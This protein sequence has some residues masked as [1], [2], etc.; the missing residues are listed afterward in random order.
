MLNG[1]LVARHFSYIRVKVKKKAARFPFQTDRDDIFGFVLVRVLRES[2]SYDAELGTFKTWLEKRVNGAVSE[3]VRESC[4][5]SRRYPARE[6]QLK[7]PN[8]IADKAQARDSAAH[9]LTEVMNELP[10][11]WRDAL[12][13]R[14]IWD[15][16][17]DEIRLALGVTQSRAS[18]ILKR[19]LEK[20]REIL[21]LYGV[22]KVGDVL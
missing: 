12:I 5:G 16:D 10:E 13:M 14:Y 4:P 11:R 7:R 21:A 9:L 2:M 18:Q 6:V 20:M 17:V 1:D 8:H 19:A 15:C 22:V 3:A